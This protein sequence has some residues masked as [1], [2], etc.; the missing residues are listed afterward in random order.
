MTLLRRHRPLVAL[1]LL[2]AVARTV[3]AWR[4]VT[5]VL[6]PD[7]YIYSELARSLGASGL[8]QIRGELYAFPALLASLVTAPAWLVQDVGVAYRIAQAEGAVAVSLAAVPAYGLALR[9]GVESRLA[10]LAAATAVLVPDAVSAG[11]LASEPFAYPLF[12]AAL[13]ALVVSLSGGGR[14][15]RVALLCLT[16]AACLARVQLLVLPIAYAVAL[17][18][19]SGRRRSLRRT[20]RLH[21]L[22]V[23]T[24]LAAAVAAAAAGPA[25]AAGVYGALFDAGIGPGEL[26]HWM[27]IDAV[28]VCVAAGWLLV[29]G[30]AL[31]LGS[32]VWRPASRAEEV[33][34]WAA[35]TLTVLLLAE[36]AFFGRYTAQLVE[37]YA[38]YA[39]PIV[40][41]AFALAHERGLLRSRAHVAGCAA[42]AVL[43]V[44][45]PLVDDLFFSSPDQ[46]PVLLAYA[47]LHRLLDWRAPIVAGPVLAGLA[48]LA[49]VLCARGRAF[50]ATVVAA[51]LCLTVTAFASIELQSHS[52]IVTDGGGSFVD[53]AGVGEAPYLA[54]AA[55]SR[56][57][58]LT[59]L[60]W[61][62]TVD[63]VLRA[64]PGT[65]GFA[66]GDARIRGDGAIVAGGRVVHGPLVVDRTGALASFSSGTLVR[67]TRTAELWNGTLRLGQLVDGY[68][69]VGRWLAAKGSIRAW[70]PARVQLTLRSDE[71]RPQRLVF[72]SGA[73]RIA[74]TVEARPRIVTLPVARARWTWLSEG[75]WTLTNGHLVAL[76]VD[77]IRIL[78]AA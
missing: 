43:G 1:V 70:S 56:G 31:G 16:A 15:S 75:T 40:V 67:R 61:N 25:R 3:L 53:R 65:D 26:A 41:I 45:S 36:A 7:E 57:E 2:A 12:L 21:A 47:P 74:L 63:R 4:Q 28:I 71:N 62:R 24:F 54:F 20:L 32:A 13:W 29:P 72:R 17:V 35:V 39:A 23:G 55:T 9:L 22:P 60:F 49:L 19:V 42:L 10:L 8:P 18:A 5:P 44:L 73:R 77:S 11:L 38:F 76:H 66:A 6:L 37:R 58:T 64:G 30:A 69:G 14:A 48:V 34:G 46:S 78:P 52:R 27:A 33:F 50:A 51:G 68:Y 59:T